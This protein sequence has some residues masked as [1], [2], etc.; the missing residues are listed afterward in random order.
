MS[1]SGL[2]V[3]YSIFLDTLGYETSGGITRPT[4]FT[5][6]VRTG[7]PADANKIDISAF[8][9]RATYSESNFMRLEND[10]SFD[11]INGFAPA[12]PSGALQ[13]STYIAFVPDF[14]T[15]NTTRKLRIAEYSTYKE[16]TSDEIRHA[17]FYGVIVRNPVTGLI[18]GTVPSN[19]AFY[20]I[21]PGNLSDYDRHS[22]WTKGSRLI[23][24]YKATGETSPTN[25]ATGSL[26]NISSGNAL[27]IG[28]NTTS[29]V[30]DTCFIRDDP[31]AH[32]GDS[33]V[34]FAYLGRG[35]AD[36]VANGGQ[37]ISRTVGV[38]ALA[39]LDF[40]EPTDANVQAD[41]VAIPAG[42]NFAIYKI[43]YFPGSHGIVVGA[44]NAVYS[45]FANAIAATHIYDTDPYLGFN[46]WL[47]AMHLG[48]VA[49]RSTFT[50][51]SSWATNAGLYQFY[52]VNKRAYA[53]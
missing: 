44:S 19:L 50:P 17:G 47:P 51:T 37:V 45:S 35:I 6:N 41:L 16:F 2:P 27:T 21:S 38:S 23:S 12:W 13:A 24:G 25:G 30:Y 53:G 22:I 11:A 20:R 43:Y 46:R 1:L 4:V 5:S 3:N 34:S 15:K 9:S 26:F 52:D 36:G 48:Y 14:S 33:G 18:D 39:N 32:G 40:Y 8:F 31:I 42:A 28:R 7:N 29:D 49:A 10:W